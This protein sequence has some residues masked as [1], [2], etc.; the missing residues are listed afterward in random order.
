MGLPLKILVC[1]VKHVIPYMENLEW[2]K[3]VDLES[4]KLFLNI[5]LTSYVLETLKITQKRWMTIN[6]N[7]LESIYITNHNQIVMADMDKIYHLRK[8]K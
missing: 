6:S 3:L 2:E 7:T 8:L 4:F 5:L 1:R